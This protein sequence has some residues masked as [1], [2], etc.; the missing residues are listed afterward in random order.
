[1]AKPTTAAQINSHPSADQTLPAEPKR[2]SRTPSSSNLRNA[3]RQSVRTEAKNRLIALKENGQHITMAEMVLQVQAERRAELMAKRQ[4]AQE[5]RRAQQL[6]NRATRTAELAAKKAVKRAAAISAPAEAEAKTPCVRK[7]RRAKIKAHK[8]STPPLLRTG[9]DIHELTETL[10]QN[11]GD[12][13][14]VQAL[15]QSLR[16]KGRHSAAANQ[17][18]RLS[19][20]MLHHMLL[21]GA[22]LQHAGRHDEAISMLE[23]LYW[24]EQEHEEVALQLG[25]AQL[26]LATQI[27]DRKDARKQMQEG[28][29]TLTP[30]LESDSHGPAA[31]KAMLA[32]H[33]K[34]GL[35]QDGLALIRNSRHAATVPLHLHVSLALKQAILK[36]DEDAACAA[37]SGCKPMPEFDLR[38]EQGLRIRFADPDTAG[39]HIIHHLANAEI[40][41]T[42]TLLGALYRLQATDAA[43]QLAA[44]TTAPTVK[45]QPDK[46]AA[47]AFYM[48]AGRAHL[49]KAEEIEFANHAA[50]VPYGRIGY[51]KEESD[52]L[53]HLDI[54]FNLLATALPLKVNN[55]EAIRALSETVVF[56]NT[57][58][59]R[60]IARTPEENRE[61]AHRIAANGLEKRLTAI[62][63]ANAK[64]NSSSSKKR[65]EQ[66]SQDAAAMGHKMAKNMEREDRDKP[67]HRPNSYTQF[68]GVRGGYS[69]A[70]R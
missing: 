69:P 35:A 25:Q 24:R 4:T 46:K 1:M 28:L 57:V 27:K 19:D 22:D 20:P 68:G 52:G 42:A 62:L 67:A 48:V 5:E 40:A 55:P 45:S 56:S 47:L 17:L 38:P 23:P 7:A 16:R 11:P 63:Q 53:S 3:A 37:L 2:A 29:S 36:R 39:S 44:Q 9:R 60:M 8:L 65:R 70:T 15:A 43:I 59:N 18:L 33:L 66:T 61:E 58:A 51:T 64:P 41:P 30:L 12:R 21:I 26:G 32:A 54:A 13:L 10:E 31:L 14:V 34:V 49:R 50:V 6:Q